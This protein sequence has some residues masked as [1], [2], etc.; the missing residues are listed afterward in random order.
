[1]GHLRR[2]AHLAGGPFEDA[3]TADTATPYRLEISGDWRAAVA[4]WT[5]RYGDDS[6]TQ[7]RNV[8]RADPFAPTIRW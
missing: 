5:R 3:P 8:F 2:W 1:V 7:F 6:R 4:E